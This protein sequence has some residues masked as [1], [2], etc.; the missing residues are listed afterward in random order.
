MPV[1]KIYRLNAAFAMLVTIAVMAALP[2]CISPWFGSKDVEEP[3]DYNWDE[4]HVVGD[5]AIPLGLNS[6]K[7]QGVSMVTELRGTGSDPNPSPVRDMLL[8]EM[9]IRQVENPQ[10][11]LASPHTSLVVLE[12]VIPPGA[13]KGDRVDVS[14]D[15]TSDSD[16][17]SL[18]HGY[19]L[20]GRMTEKAMLGGRIREGKKIARA[21]GPIVL[22]SVIEGTKNSVTQKR[23]VI[24]G[25]AELLE[26]RP[27]ALGLVEG[28]ASVAASAR[29]GGAINKRFFMYVRG[30][31]EGVATPKN[32]KIVALKVHPKYHGNIPRYVN[33]IRN[34]P[35]SQA[36]TYR[37]K[38]LGELQLELLN[39]ETTQ[40]AAMKL[41]AMGDESLPVLKKGLES[42][43]ELVRFC[44]AEALAYLD[45]HASIEPLREAAANSN[46]FRYRAILALGSMDELEAFDAL[47]TLLHAEGAETRYGA[48]DALK[49]K[50]SHLPSIRGVKLANDIQLHHVRSETN[51]MIHVR[52]VDRPEIVLFGNDTRLRG[53]VTYLGANGLTIRSVDNRKVRITRFVSRGD[54]QF[55]E[56]ESDVKEVIRTLVDLG[57]EYGEVIRTLFALREEEYILARVEVNAMPRSD[58]KYLGDSDVFSDT[59]ESE[60]F[61]DWD[62][63]EDNVE[64]NEED[65]DAEE[66]EVPTGGD[67][68]IPE[69]D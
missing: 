46:A 2:G 60:E 41:E 36:T 23:G 18:E 22:E 34:V 66:I 45:Q 4:V 62:T 26:E 38:R 48:F 13:R 54:D 21:S 8:Q 16:T 61:D 63:D 64:M 47:E 31:K 5:L 52:M 1:H 59:E 27:L 50:A 49:N 7:V 29:I 25:G 30:S 69:F 35:L 9:R 24:L 57:A 53:P 39:E 51:P 65:E 42:Q 40:L 58:R 14:V 55:A 15:V 28:R 33:V 12:T 32:D 6:A 11:Q 56:C 67:I 43:S 10:R 3:A 17:T 20:E 44:S 68:V 19:C 37:V